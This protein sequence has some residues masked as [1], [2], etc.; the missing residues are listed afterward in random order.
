MVD[1]RVD[2]GT[3][4]LEPLEGGDEVPRDVAAGARAV[5][6]VG[7]EERQVEDDEHAEQD[8]EHADCPSRRVRVAAATSGVV[9]RLGPD[10]STTFGRILA[11]YVYSSQFVVHSRY[12]KVTEYHT[13]ASID[14]TLLIGF[15]P[16]R[17]MNH[18]S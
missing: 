6:R 3:A 14:G 11:T 2:D 5:D 16:V 18:I 7:D 12:R 13:P 9:R 8:A 4:V 17:G 15:E 10:L 1:D